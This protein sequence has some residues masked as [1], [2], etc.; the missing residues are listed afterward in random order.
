M[1][2]KL[3]MQE[4]AAKASKVTRTLRI[5]VSNTAGSQYIPSNDAGEA[6]FDMDTTRT[7]NWLLKVEGRLLDVSVLLLLPFMALG[8]M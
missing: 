2:R 5:F 4:N 1:R 3:D 6:I 7:P 8:L